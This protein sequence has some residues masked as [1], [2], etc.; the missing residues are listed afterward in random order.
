MIGLRVSEVAALAIVEQADYYQ[1][2]SD[3]ALAQR[4]EA[5]VDQAIHSLLQQPERGT[6]CRFRSPSLA[7]VRWILV[8]GFPKHMIIYRF[9]HHEQAIQII[10]VLHGARDL[11]TLFDRDL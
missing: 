4:W 7:G 11:E 3:T 10:H 5:A 1:Q 2:A 8:S 9:S 6:L